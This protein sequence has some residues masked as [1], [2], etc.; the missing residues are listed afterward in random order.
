MPGQPGA[1]PAARVAREARACRQRLGVPVPTSTGRLPTCA[2]TWRSRA[3]SAPIIPSRPT[4][5]WRTSA[6]NTGLTACLPI[7]SGGL[8]VLAGD[9]LKSASGLDLPLVAV[10]LLYNHGY[11]VQYLDDNGWQ[12]ERYRTQDFGTLPIKPVMEGETGARSRT[13]RDGDDR[14][15]R[16]S[17]SL[18]ISPVAGC[19]RRCGGCRW[20]DPPLPARHLCARERPRQRSGSPTSSM[21]EVPRNGWRRSWCSA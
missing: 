11:F 3:G 7:Y 12:R 9:H 1:A 13:G 15:E 17:R 21:A 4:P 19:G 2:T 8:G 20:A 18:W 6:W 16:R 10:G 14:G 5:A